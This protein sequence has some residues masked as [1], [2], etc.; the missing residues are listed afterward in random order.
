MIGDDVVVYCITHISPNDLPEFPSAVLV[1]I[2]VATAT[3]HSAALQSE[4]SFCAIWLKMNDTVHLDSKAC[5][6]WKILECLKVPAL[7]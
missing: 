5:A 6:R 7:I 4:N 1:S 3:P 2:D